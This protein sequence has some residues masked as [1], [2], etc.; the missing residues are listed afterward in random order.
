MDNLQQIRRMFPLVLWAV[1]VLVS[2]PALLAQSNYLEM[3][4]PPRTGAT[5]E[6]EMGYVNL[7]NGN[8]HL[9]VP[10]GSFPQRGALS[11]SAKLAYDSRIWTQV[12]GSPTFVPPFNP[13][14]PIGGFPSSNNGGWRLV[15]S[16][17]PAMSAPNSSAISQ[18][19]DS[20]FYPWGASWQANSG[21]SWQ[22]ADGTVHS[23]DQNMLTAQM[24]PPGLAN[25]S[26]YGD[27]LSTSGYATDGSGLLMVVTNFNN[28]TVYDKNGNQ[29]YPTL[30]D[31]N[32][33]YFSHDANN[34]VIDTL[35]RTP[36][37]T[38]TVGSTIYYDVL[39]SLGT[40]STYTVQTTSIPVS[41][42]GYSGTLTVVSSI[43]LPNNAVYTFGYDSG[44]TGNNWGLINYV[45]LPAG[46]EITYGY[47]TFTDASGNLD[48]EN[49]WVTSKTSAGSTWFY[50]P[51]VTGTGTQQITLKK[52]SGDIIV[53]KSKLDCMGSGFLNKETDYFDASNTL[54]KQEL[55]DYVGEASCPGGGA[56]PTGDPNMGIARLTT[57]KFAPSGALTTK[58]EF[59]YTNSP[60]SDSP[61]RISEWNYYTGAAPASPDRVRMITYSL[62]GN[63]TLATAHI[64]GK[65][66]LV[67]LTDKA[68]NQIAQTS[69]SYDDYIS[70]PL[71]STGNCQSTSASQP[72]P[73]APQHDYQAYCTSN[74]VRGNLTQI[75]KWLNATNSLTVSVSNIYDDT[76]NVAGSRDALSN[77]TQFEYSPSFGRAY[78]TKTTD[79]LNHTITR[80]YDQNTGLLTTSTDA[81]N[82][83]TRYTY[84][85]MGR[86]KTVNYPDGGQITTD[87][88]DIAPISV[89]TT[90]LATPDPSIVQTATVDAYGRPS[91]KCLADPE[92]DTCAETAYDANGRVY[93]TT[94]PHRTV[95]AA[96]DGTTFFSYD[97]L[98]R[99]IV[100]TEPDNNVFTTSYDVQSS[101]VVGQ[102]VTRTD[103]TLRQSRT[104]NDGFGRIIEA[105]EPGDSFAGARAY[106]SI[107]IGQIKTT[108]V[109]GTPGNPATV[110]ITVSGTNH[111]KT[112]IVRCNLRINPDCQNQVLV[113]YDT[114]KVFITV[115][116]HEY[117]YFFGGV[118]A[119]DSSS[120]VALGLVGV[121]QQDSAR[122]VNASVPPS[123]STITLTAVAAGTAGNGISFA[124]GSTWNSNAFP[125]QGPSFTASPASGSLS[126]GTAATSGTPVTDHGT[127]TATAGSFTT[128]AVPYGP[129]TANTTA[130]AVATALA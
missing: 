35:G 45:K 34:N 55:I 71:V 112:T 80:G 6:V 21:F 50:T 40:R 92:G 99:T 48:S 58:T 126:G 57:V 2:A 81:N 90:Q 43:T 47:T 128:P 22:D 114:G 37:I 117:D 67:T 36:V 118:N 25:C 110:Q 74:T 69:F 59:G 87:Y 123:G 91:Q 29:L 49:R 11:F 72:S 96:T 7:N 66:L 27:I 111:S 115:A 113:T 73:A 9:E 107:D 93:S 14:N 122:I 5:A 64:I 23:F 101:P 129:G 38:R 12:N 70:N 119:P 68:N 18:L 86:P 53:Y 103:E 52:P 97:G 62:S 83:V 61:T 124:T 65:P 24:F 77:L 46:G 94:N 26:P 130:N 32:G 13:I 79:A 125:T 3:L 104:V 56:T 15:I 60:S 95:A 98:D 120:S 88:T 121:I 1:V 44:T 19:C 116:G 108:Q 16:G 10:L 39:N 54:L 4:G 33:N 82:N 84:D 28:V 109:G 42:P 105:A 85:S 63:S 76:G 51:Q 8:L 127:V 17:D 100:I 89:K 20:N 106:G 41:V 102:T 75:S 78:L 30:K 31:T